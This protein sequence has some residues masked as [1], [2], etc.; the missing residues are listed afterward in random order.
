MYRVIGASDVT[1]SPI[2]KRIDVIVDGVQFLN[3][4]LP[5]IN[6]ET[7]GK[8]QLIFVFDHD[9]I[10]DDSEYI[11]YYSTCSTFGT[12]IVQEAIIAREQSRSFLVNMY[13]PNLVVT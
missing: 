3:S 9:Q 5:Y 11:Q 4:S 12:E 8:G 13:G 6:I 2:Q 10:L 7:K 1:K